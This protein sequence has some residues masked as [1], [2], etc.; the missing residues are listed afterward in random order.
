M[1]NP[2]QSVQR[3][4]LNDPDAAEAVCDLMIWMA[5]QSDL[6]DNS[7]YIAAFNAAFVKTNHC[8]ECRLEYEK[9]RT[10]SVVPDEARTELQPVVSTAAKSH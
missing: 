7:D 2:Q 4:L 10:E 9:S 8:E 3:I 6:K 1:I 5:N